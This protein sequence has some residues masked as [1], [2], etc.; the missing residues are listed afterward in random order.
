M[1]LSDLFNVSRAVRRDKA[2][3]QDLLPTPTSARGIS[4]RLCNICYTTAASYT[5]P[6]CNIPYCSLA[7]FRSSAHEQ[8]SAAFSSVA[9]RGAS[10]SLASETNDGDRRKVF[11]MLHRLQ[12][13]ETSARESQL[14]DSD[15]ESEDTEAGA[16]DALRQAAVTSEQVEA[17][18]TDELLAMLTE[19][20]KVRFLN[21]MKSQQSATKLV[22]HLD[23]KAA[24]HTSASSSR[25]SEGAVTLPR[26]EAQPPQDSARQTSSYQ[27][28][29][30]FKK[31]D[32]FIDFTGRS[33]EQVS[34]FVDT[35]TKLA[36]AKPSGSTATNARPALD[37][38]YNLCAVLMTYAYVLRHL[39]TTN[40]SELTRPHKDPTIPATS[41][42][43]RLRSIIPPVFQDTFGDMDDD[44][45]PPL[46]PDIPEPAPPAPSI[47]TST[48]PRLP[49]QSV[50]PPSLDD[51][52]T[53]H[54]AL[55]KLRTLAPFLFS[56]TA[57]GGSSTPHDKSTTVLPTLED[58]SLWILSHLS[59]DT[60]VGPGGADA[61]ALQLLEDLA[62]ILAIER[63]VPSLDSGDPVEPRHWLVSRFTALQPETAFSIAQSPSLL[64]AVA[65]LYFFLDALAS[66]GR[67]RLE[68]SVQKSLK[69]TQRKLCFYLSNALF[70]KQKSSEPTTRDLQLEL[71][72]ALE[73]TRRRID[74]T[75]DAEKLTS[76]LSLMGSDGAATTSD[77]R[78]PVRDG[79]SSPVNTRI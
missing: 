75:R 44:G 18:S 9:V 60:E 17:A 11:D 49:H 47:P 68:P 19:K 38:R 77:I 63:L 12:A 8:C 4:A 71:Q 15:S 36:A 64:S 52:H 59:L 48:S 39:D 54:A 2:R 45:P 32:A 51:V 55:D 74:A 33:E 66:D 13:D 1:S 7:C 10:E 25:E 43:D 28:A 14:R 37:L 73:T 21:A 31:P 62:S 3:E 29:P 5:C 40:L 22:R 35:L 30:W 57:R 67:D 76:A 41:D 46:E 16:E 20:Q 58:A 42:T 65:D 26:L 56:H 23:Q 6:K 50:S 53:A 61:L 79:S 78:L 72:Y 27:S 24:R 34:S 69:L 70:R